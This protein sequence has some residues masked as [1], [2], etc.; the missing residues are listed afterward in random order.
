MDELQ[1]DGYDNNCLILSS[2]M[3]LRKLPQEH[4]T[5]HSVRTATS[6]ERRRVHDSL[7]EELTARGEDEGWSLGMTLKRVRCETDEIDSPLAPSQAD[8][9]PAPYR[10]MRFSKN[11]TSCTRPTST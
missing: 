8:P 7:K 2:F 9:P 1:N 6:T 5:A 10:L 11:A 4:C 3:A